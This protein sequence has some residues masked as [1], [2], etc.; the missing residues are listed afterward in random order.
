MNI[1]VMT[2]DDIP[3]AM[4]VKAQNRW[5]QL[6]ADWR[7]Q[8]AL[9]PEGSFVAELDSV[10]VGTACACVFGDVAWIN[11]VLVEQQQRGKGIGTALMRHVLHWLDDRR[12][13]TIRLDATSLGQPVYGKLGFTGDFTLHRFEGNLPS[14]LRGRGAAAFLPSPSGRGAGGEGPV[15]LPSPLRGRG[16][17]GEGAASCEISQLLPSDLSAIS[18][19][20]QSITQTSREKLLHSLQD[21]HPTLMRKCTIANSLAGYAFCRSGSNAWQLGPILGTPAAGRAL[22]LDAAERFAGECVYMD[23]PAD[24]A[25]AIAVAQALGLTVQRSFLRMTRGRRIVEDVHRTWAS[26]GPEKG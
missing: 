15:F 22:L 14:P 4:R 23:I 11:M 18:A 19:L 20:D 12:V 1:R 10:P 5:N 7:R 2:A 17:G 8:L 9:E 24:N 21:A 16:A 25:D 26:S 6:E 13:P 3:F